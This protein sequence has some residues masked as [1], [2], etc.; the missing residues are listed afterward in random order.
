MKGYTQDPRFWKRLRDFV[1]DIQI[2][3][4]MSEEEKDMILHNCEQKLNN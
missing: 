3:D 2:N 1:K 4:P